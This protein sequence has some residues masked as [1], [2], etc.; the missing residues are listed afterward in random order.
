VHSWR[1]EYEAAI[2]L[3]T[4][5]LATLPADGALEFFGLPAP[6]AIYTRFWLVGSLAQVG[7]FAEAAKC[8][9]DLL[10]L[11]K[12]SQLPFAVGVAHQVIATSHV[13]RGDWGQARPQIE[14]AL[15]V[16]RTNNM[17]IVLP[18]AI[19]ICASVM[20]HVGEVREALTRLQEGDEFLDRQV[21]QGMITQHLSGAYHALARGSLVLGRLDDARRLVDRAV[22]FS[23]GRPGVMTYALHLLGDIATHND[24]FDAETGEAHYR[25]ALALAEPRGMR[26]V[27]G[28]CHF[29]LGKLYQ[30]IGK[31]EEARMHLATAT[32]MYR[33]MDMSFY[34]KQ[35][36]AETGPKA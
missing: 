1:A 27:V 13:L 33:E 3:A 7:R 11:A 34:L 20:A 22:E 35:A 19:A 17:A 2:E 36:E 14:Q 21:A 30:R 32:T 6:A 16:F 24:R 10:Q 12:S 25:Q 18:G 23:G 29:G 4:A 31:Q 28:H 8:G 15:A 9:A 5:N 26:P